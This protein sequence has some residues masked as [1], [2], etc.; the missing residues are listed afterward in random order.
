MAELY[1][2]LRELQA[3]DEMFLQN[4]PPPGQNNS[5]HQYAAAAQDRKYERMLRIMNNQL[6]LLRTSSDT[7]VI[8]LK[9]EISDLMDEKVQTEIALMNRLALLEREKMS[10][11]E[12]IGGG[13][14][15]QER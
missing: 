11:E 1:R 5:Q 15:K 9:D 7:L 13:G 6:S 8:S 12:I 14:A 2:D 3:S 10:L 4:T